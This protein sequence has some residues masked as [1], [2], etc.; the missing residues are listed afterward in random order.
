MLLDAAKGFYDRGVNVSVIVIDYM[1]WRY[2]GDFSFDPKS[3]P[4]VPGMMKTLDG[5]GM[6]VRRCSFRGS[7]LAED[8]SGSLSVLPSCCGAGDGVCL[9]VSVEEQQHQVNGYK[10]QLGND[11]SGHIFTCRLGRQQL[12]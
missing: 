10:K 2:M 11:C 8:I 9:A 4:D 5:Y 3:W 7:Q 1:H 12:C 6:R